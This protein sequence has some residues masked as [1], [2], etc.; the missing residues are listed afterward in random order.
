MN[1]SKV[2]IY[3]ITNNQ[4]CYVKFRNLSNGKYLNISDNEIYGNQNGTI[5]II[6]PH[7]FSSSIQF[8]LPESNHYLCAS[9]NLSNARID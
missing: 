4:L 9:K 7:L 5:I 1:L 3:L 6:K 2:L 8:L